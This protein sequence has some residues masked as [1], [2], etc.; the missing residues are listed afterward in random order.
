MMRMTGKKPV[1]SQG[2][3]LECWAHCRN[4]LVDLL[5]AFQKE[6]EGRRAVQSR[7]VWLN[8]RACRRN[9]PVVRLEAFR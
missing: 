9:R 5:Q 7:G 1:H 6:A 3:R 8:C 2:H 4:R